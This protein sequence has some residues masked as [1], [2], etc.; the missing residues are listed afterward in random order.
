VV[1]KLALKLREGKRRRNLKSFVLLE[2]A[3]VQ[4]A[5]LVVDGV[6]V[7]QEQAQKEVE[8]SY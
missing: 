2:L 1:Q 8:T 6:S 3:W 7:L 4:L 5:G